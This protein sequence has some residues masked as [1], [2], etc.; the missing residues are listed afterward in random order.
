MSA[1]D[2]VLSSTDLG[3]DIALDVGRLP[4]D[5]DQIKDWV[6][7][8]HKVTGTPARF[9]LEKAAGTNQ[10]VLNSSK[11][12]GIQAGGVDFDVSFTA[13][14]AEDGDGRPVATWL[15]QQN[16][17][18]NSPGSAGMHLKDPFTG[19]NVATGTYTLEAL[20]ATGG[21]VTPLAQNVDPQKMGCGD[22][23]PTLLATLAARP[24][25]SAVVI[26]MRGT[27]VHDPAA[28]AMN[29][30]FPPEVN[31]Q[32]VL[33][34]IAVTANVGAELRLAVVV[35]PVKGS[36]APV[37]FGRIH[38]LIADVTGLP[39]GRTCTFAWSVVSGGAQVSGEANQQRCRVE[40]ARPRE[41]VLVQVV[42]SL[43]GVQATGQ[44]NLTVLPEHMERAAT[45][46]FRGLVAVGSRLEPV[47]RQPQ[48]G[49]PPGPLSVERLR[50]TETAASNLAK[51]AAKLRQELETDR[52][53]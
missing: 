43:L 25:P 34:K 27:H 9:C 12:L 5:D 50:A 33:G 6:H 46:Y 29:N 15:A 44:I 47:R 37:Y 53:E 17:K 16:V 13:S 23:P 22:G 20:S 32:I 31:F 2:D 41:P 1:T 3:M 35:R 26:V 36:L 8:G 11:H 28:G 52:S 38:D 45:D 39:P 42:A 24:E 30:F 21:F 10:L 40:V 18:V 14:F 48:P 19:H 4:D 7:T 51:A 49:P